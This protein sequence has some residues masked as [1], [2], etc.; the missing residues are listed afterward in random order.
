MNAG[1]AFRCK[2]FDGFL[3]PTL[4]NGAYL[5]HNQSYNLGFL[6]LQVFFFSLFII[7]SIVVL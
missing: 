1:L 2:T 5:Y 6:I 3:N 4:L 7:Y